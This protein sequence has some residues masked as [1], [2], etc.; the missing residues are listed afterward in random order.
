MKPFDFNQAI[1]KWIRQLRKHPGFEDA[2]V[3]EMANHIR[4]RV[5]HLLIE[6]FTEERAF[7]KAIAEFGEADAIGFDL[8]LSKQPNTPKA[9]LFH[10]LPGWL[11]IFYRSTLKN[12]F[13]HSIS[14]S[15]LAVGMAAALVIYKL[16]VFELSYDQHFSHHQNIYRLEAKF[17]QGGKWIPSANNSWYAGQVVAE[18]LSGIEEI[19]RI[20]P[21]RATLVKGDQEIFEKNMAITS[22]NFFQVFDLPFVEGNPQAAFQDNATIVLSQSMAKRHFGEQ[23][24]LGKVLTLKRVDRPLRV[25][26]VM[27]DIPSNTHFQK[28]AIINIEG[29]KDLYSEKFFNHPGWTSCF[30]YVKLAPKTDIEGLTSQFPNIIETH[31]GSTYSNKDTE[32]VLRPLTDIHLYSKSGEEL[33]VN[34]DLGQLK[35]LAIMAGLILLLAILNYLN[36]ST[37]RFITRIREMAIRKTAGASKMQIFTQLMSETLMHFFVSL[38]FGIILIVLISPILGN[39]TP[40]SVIYNYSFLEGVLVIFL[41]LGIALGSGILPASFFSSQNP[42]QVLASR[43]VQ[44]RGKPILRKALVTFQFMITVGM[45][46]ATAVVYYQYQFIKNYDR[47]YNVESVLAVPKYNMKAETWQTL[48]AELLKH[49]N[50]QTIGASSLV[51]P[52]ALQSSISYRTPNDEGEKRAMKAVRTDGDF[53][54]VF[55]IQMEEGRAFTKKYNE[56]SPEVILNEK[57]A[58]LL[59][60][61]NADDKW[62]EPQHLK[63]SAEVVGFVKDINFESLKNEIIPTAFLLDP[64]NSHIMYLRLGNGDLTST[65][66]FV[67]EKFHDFSENRFEHWFVEETLTQQFAQEQ[68]FTKVF[69]LFTLI[70]IIIAFAGLYGLSRFV[71]ERRTKEI[72]IRKVLGAS[73]LEVL[74][75]ILKGFFVLALLAYVIIAPV[76]TILLKDWLAN[77][78]YH[79]SLDAKIF[80]L[81]L[82]ATLLLSSAA[83]IYQVLRASLRNPVNALR[84]E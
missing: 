13:Y 14:I 58:S 10:M 78:A 48:K 82:V 54:H 7:E 71:C 81:T 35:F 47:G 9:N 3:I 80:L 24:A 6:G 2:D 60:W 28:D 45:L 57:A 22:A 83:V 64:A 55:Q 63:Y 44:L 33:S 84:Y 5:D 68:T 29:L 72:G 51:F 11:K 31:L 61:E 66:K 49:N 21:G 65:I 26:G 41:V 20:T 36:L 73:S 1:E 59:S 37:A 38:A 56:E 67:K 79:T 40:L 75:I 27:K 17:H 77:F 50:I 34:G 19:V 53:F 74:W 8:S 69:S 30:T 23:P 46:I 15:S 25:A 52:G 12:K 32:F 18:N 70:A 43:T 42:N 4:D 16:V 76:I 62:F 39:L